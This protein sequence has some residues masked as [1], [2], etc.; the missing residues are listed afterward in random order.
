MRIKATRKGAREKGDFRRGNE[1]SRG[2][3]KCQ[4]PEVRTWIFFPTL[5]L[6][7]VNK[8]Q[9]STFDSCLR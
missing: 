1:I 8:V 5:S 2:N 6:T 9:K 4:G 3:N 7:F